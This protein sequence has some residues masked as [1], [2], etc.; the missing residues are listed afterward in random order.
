MFLGK[1]IKQSM[2]PAGGLFALLGLL[3]YYIVCARSPELMEIRKTIYNC[4]AINFVF[5]FIA[6]MSYLWVDNIEAK[7][8]NRKTF[9]SGIDWF[10][11]EI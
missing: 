3:I 9:D 7:I 5:I 1:S 8:K 4:V 2:L 6:F 10:W 11:K